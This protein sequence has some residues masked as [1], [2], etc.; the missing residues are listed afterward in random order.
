MLKLG[1]LFSINKFDTVRAI[2][3]TA[4]YFTCENITF[5]TMRITARYKFA[6]S[7]TSLYIW[8]FCSRVITNKLHFY[9]LSFFI[10]LKDSYMQQNDEEVETFI[11]DEFNNRK[12]LK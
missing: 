12:S 4:R 10:W 6:K 2:I 9:K 11:E 7:Q 5:H 3:F 1:L 8:A